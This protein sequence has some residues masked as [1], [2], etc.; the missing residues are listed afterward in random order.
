[1]MGAGGGFATFPM[2]VYVFGVSS[3]TT[4]GQTFFRSSLPQA[5]ASISQYAIYGYHL[6][7][8]SDGNAARLPGWNPGR[9]AYNQDDQRHSY[10]GLL[11]TVSILAG[12]VDRPSVLPRR[13]QQLGAVNLP[14]SL[15]V[16]IQNVGDLIFWIVCTIFAVWLFAKF[17]GGL[18][19]LREE[20]AVAGKTLGAASRN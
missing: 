10:P 4:V 6:L 18:K 3:M 11:C 9:R 7:F 2:F 1:M 15:V 5:L 13:M 19:S 14:K 17:I 8:Y 16:G 12:F 20:S